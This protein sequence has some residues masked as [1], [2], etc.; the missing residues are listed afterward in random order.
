MIT[1]A[2]ATTTSQA[3]SAMVT[4]LITASIHPLFAVDFTT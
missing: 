2:A 1:K 4:Y 3:I